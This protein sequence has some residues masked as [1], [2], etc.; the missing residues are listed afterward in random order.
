MQDHVC[1]SSGT[2]DYSARLV[3]SERD[4]VL[5][6]PK[7]VAVFR[8]QLRKQDQTTK[9]GGDSH[10][11]FIGAAD[12]IEIEINTALIHHRQA[13]QERDFTCE[14]VETGAAR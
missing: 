1:A 2:L 6:S 4:A 12:H 9:R 11:I 5:L 7:L 14:G 13:F 3:R 10:L 8:L